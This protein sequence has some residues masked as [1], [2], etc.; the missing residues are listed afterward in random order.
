M[1]LLAA[2]PP[3]AFAQAASLSET[4][5]V[6]RIAECLI[7]GPPSDWQTLYMVIELAE[8]GAQTG[9][10]RYLAVRESAPEKPEPYVPCDLKKPA[11][12]LIEARKWQPPERQSWTGARLTLHENG[13]FEINYDYPK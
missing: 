8:A 6:A 13:K 1:L 2:A 3:A 12:L 11:Q 10:V 9:Q 4:N 5:A 7:V